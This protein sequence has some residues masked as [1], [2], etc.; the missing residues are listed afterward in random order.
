MAQFARSLSI[1][2]TAAAIAA[3]LAVAYF[4]VGSGF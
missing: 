2:M 4:W 1:G 3:M